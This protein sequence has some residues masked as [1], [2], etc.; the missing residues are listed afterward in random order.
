MENVKEISPC[1]ETLEGKELNPEEL[2]IQTSELIA[3]ARDEF[4]KLKDWLID[5]WEKQN[6]KDWPRYKEDVYYSNG[7]L[8][9][10]AG[11]RYDCHHIHPLNLGGKNEVSNITPL[12]CLDHFDKQGIHSAGSPYS[13]LQNLLKIKEVA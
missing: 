2:K 11:D 8:L 4:N 13:N 10:K 1:P 12:H 5:Q 7:T 6:G 9:H 3:K